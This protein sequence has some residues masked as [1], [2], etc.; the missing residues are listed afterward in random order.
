MFKKILTTESKLCFSRLEMAQSADSTNTMNVVCDE[1]KE[2]DVKRTL[3]P[4]IKAIYSNPHLVQQ[5][6][7][8]VANL[9]VESL[10]KIVQWL[11]HYPVC[12]I[13]LIDKEY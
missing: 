12:V 13:F 1:D 6:S 9:R 4:R 5:D 10:Q 8:K 2:F 11:E 7:I 3:L